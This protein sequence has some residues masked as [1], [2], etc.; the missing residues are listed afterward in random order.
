MNITL[1]GL[2]IITASIGSGKSHFI[3]YI[4]YSNQKKFSYGIVFS[5]T[6]FNEKNFTYIPKQFIHSTYNPDILLNLMKIQESFPQESRPLAFVILDDCLFDS[7]VNCKYFNRLITQVRHY[8]IFVIISTQYVNK[9]SPMIRENAMQVAIFQTDVER[10]L[11]S[12]YESYGQYFKTLQD[13]KTYIMKN[14]GDYKFIW[15]DRKNKKYSIM[16]CP[17]KIPKFCLYF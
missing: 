16:R 14:T 15:Y 10:S 6:A 7:W 17:K 5:H 2:I 3:K 9:V 4:M 13:F 12:L 8:N 1:P 11:K